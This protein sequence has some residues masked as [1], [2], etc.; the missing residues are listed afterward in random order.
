M[1]G[2]PWTGRSRG[3]GGRTGWRGRS[4][5]DAVTVVL[6]LS[7]PKTLVEAGQPVRSFDS[8]PDLPSSRRLVTSKDRTVF[9]R[10]GLTQAE[11][12][13]EV[14]FMI[15]AGSDTTATTMRTTILNV[16]THPNVYLELKRDIFKA[17]REGKAS[18]PVKYEE[19]LTLPYSICRKRSHAKPAVIHEGLRMR[20]WSVSPLHRGV[21]PPSYT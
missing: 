15:T 9:L 12:E 10:N 5:H 2:C 11:I 20:P 1:L 6:A 8:L 18:N 3:R 17:A 21:F 7:T 14:V 19:A 4:V 13:H 16:I